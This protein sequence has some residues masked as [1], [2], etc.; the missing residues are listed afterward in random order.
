MSRTS[1]Q[2]L[3]LVWKV[4]LSFLSTFFNKVTKAEVGLIDA[5]AA[6]LVSLFWSASSVLFGAVLLALVYIVFIE[7]FRQYRVRRRRVLHDALRIIEEQ[8]QD[9]EI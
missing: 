4:T 2:A 6:A 3:R 8:M 1:G 7:G 9:D 5:F